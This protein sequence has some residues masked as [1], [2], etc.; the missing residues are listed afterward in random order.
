MNDA[1]LTTFL[2]TADGEFEIT[3]GGTWYGDISMQTAKRKANQFAIAIG[4]TPEMRQW[5]NPTPQQAHRVYKSRKGQLL[6]LAI[7]L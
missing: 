4:L 2:K 7:S 5:I 3:D 6:K 1:I